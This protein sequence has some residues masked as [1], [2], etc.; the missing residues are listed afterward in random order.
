LLAKIRYARS[1]NKI[2]DIFLYTNA[3]YFDRYDLTEFLQSG[4]TRISI[5]TFFGSSELYRKYY[6]VNGYE[7]SFRNIEALAIENKKLDHPVK[8]QLH[9]RVEKPEETWKS[10][11]EYK[12]IE[13]LIGKENISWL[14]VY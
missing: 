9:L 7:R 4:V 11:D 2:A 5:S 13:T 6:G 10:T 3:L 12:K 14:E 8:I 1:K